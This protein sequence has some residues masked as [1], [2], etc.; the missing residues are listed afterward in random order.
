MPCDVRA[1]PR[2]PPALSAAPSYCPPPLPPASP[3]LLSLASSYLTWSVL[4]GL[5]HLLHPTL[6]SSLPSPAC[7]AP[8]FVL[9]RLLHLLQPSRYDSLPRRLGGV[10]KEV[11]IAL[12]IT[13]GVATWRCFEWPPLTFSDGASVS[14]ALTRRLDGPPMAWD[15]ALWGGLKWWDMLAAPA[16]ALMLGARL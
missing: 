8:A 2:S 4:A 7:D 14:V 15:E 11:C 10:I 12:I 1:V 13:G 6:L 5:A 3:S 16:V 9:L